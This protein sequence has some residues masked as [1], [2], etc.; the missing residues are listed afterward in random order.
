CAAWLADDR[1]KA[2]LADVGAGTIDQALLAV[3]PSKHQ[4]LRLAGLAEQVLIVDEAHCYDSYV[5]TELDRLIA[6]QAALGGHS[7]V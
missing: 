6:F 7:I 2:F 1:R 4:A 3:L 5:S